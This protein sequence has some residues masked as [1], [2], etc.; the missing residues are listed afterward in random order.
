[1]LPDGQPACDPRII[2]GILTLLAAL[3]GSC[4]A[5]WIAYRAY[6][7]QKDKD[8]D[9]EVRRERRK[10]YSLLFN[11]A[12]NLERTVT[13]LKWHPNEGVNENLGTVL[14]LVE[15]YQT[16][17]REIS[18]LASQPVFE[19]AS[20]IDAL[21]R[22]LLLDLRAG[23]VECLDS[24]SGGVEAA[25]MHAQQKPRIDKFR[26]S[27]A[28]KENELRRAI[29][30]EEYSDKLNVSVELVPEMKEPNQ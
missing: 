15:E 7:N 12:V 24:N 30:S 28:A 26:Q 19:A 8:R 27:F 3:L 11:S 13:K 5:L 14:S 17:L 29:R 10:A 16:S 23:F 20:S 18:I 2:Q 1:V 22:A 6:P 4:T 9:L 25:T 21:A